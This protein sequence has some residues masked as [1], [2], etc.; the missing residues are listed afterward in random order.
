MIPIQRANW[1]E[2]SIPEQTPSISCAMLIPVLQDAPDTAG[3]ERNSS[4]RI[5][6]ELIV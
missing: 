1:L 4:V 5:V 2:P 3:P 6:E